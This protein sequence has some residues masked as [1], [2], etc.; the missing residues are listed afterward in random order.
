MN[1]RTECGLMLL[2]S[3]EMGNR[4]SLGEEAGK[5]VAS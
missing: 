5:R 3:I 4:G 1:D 2:N